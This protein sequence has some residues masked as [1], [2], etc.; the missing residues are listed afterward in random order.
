MCQCGHHHETISKEQFDEA[1]SKFVSTLPEDINIEEEHE[2][3]MQKKS[4]LSRSQRDAIES[5]VYY[6]KEYFENKCD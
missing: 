6:K 4:K 3:I 2:K 1:V 5:I